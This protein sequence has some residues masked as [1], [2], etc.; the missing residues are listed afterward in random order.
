M[1]S[2]KEYLSKD[3]LWLEQQ[4]AKLQTE[5]T[6]T[7]AARDLAHSDTQKA[8]LELGAVLSSLNGS[9]STAKAELL[10]ITTK[11]DNKKGE[12]IEA[13]TTHSKTVESH[14]ATLSSLRESIGTHTESRDLLESGIKV[15]EGRKVTLTTEVAELTKKRNELLDE[16]GTLVTKLSEVNDSVV[17]L[18]KAVEFLEKKI[19]GLN[20]TIHRLLTRKVV[21]VEDILND[22]HDKL[23]KRYTNRM[24]L[25]Q[26]LDVLIKKQRG[27]LKK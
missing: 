17:T 9:I 25:S 22:N 16:I 3:I 6:T 20:E 2:L 24:G 8:R 13:S 23:F 12:L 10:E 26:E 1:S 5:K 15:L 18:E 21:L 27:D 11:I 14:G 7:E 19:E 4:L